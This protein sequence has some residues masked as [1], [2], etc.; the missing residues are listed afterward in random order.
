MQI[1]LHAHIGDQ[2]ETVTGPGCHH[3]AQLRG[4][5]RRETTDPCG[6][7]HGFASLKL[8]VLQAD[9]GPADGFL[10]AAVGCGRSVWIDHQGRFLGGVKAEAHIGRQV[11]RL[12]K[13]FRGLPLD[14]VKQ[15]EQAQFC[16]FF[17]SA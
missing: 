17:S 1:R 16:R 15:D 9:H 2:I 14:L 7:P 11:R 8:A 13:L 12:L 3:R 6:L 4:A 5:A 10:H